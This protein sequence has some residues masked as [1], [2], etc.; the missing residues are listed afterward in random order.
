MAAGFARYSSKPNKPSILGGKPVVDN[1]SMGLAFLPVF[2][3]NKKTSKNQ[4]IKIS[5]LL[6]HARRVIWCHL[7][8]MLINS[9]KCFARNGAYKKVYDNFSKMA[10]I[11]N[12]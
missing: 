10:A 3:Q 7:I 5:K 4:R 1:P 2:E 8:I 9:F 11:L 12:F 6:E